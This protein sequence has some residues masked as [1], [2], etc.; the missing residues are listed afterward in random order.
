M[1][2]IN[3]IKNIFEKHGNVMRTAELHACKLYYND[4]QNLVNDGVIE[5]IKQ[6]YY[7]FIESANEID[8]IKRLYPDAILC[9]YTALFYY[10]YSDR[11][12]AEWNLAVD[13]NISRY[14]MKIE[15]PFIKTY[16]FEP[17]LLTIGV[18]KQIIDNT[19]VNIY[20]KDRTI[21]DCLRYVAKMDREIFNKSIQKYVNDPK[22]NIPNLIE[23]SKVLRVQKKVKDLIGVWL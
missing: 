17:H 4:I 6:G 1:L 23:Y 21:C 19:Y 7:Y 5:K 13:K 15:Y 20:D 8:I 16:L 14:R 2:P 22:K 18:T 3:E 9:M 11:N 12:P 10:G